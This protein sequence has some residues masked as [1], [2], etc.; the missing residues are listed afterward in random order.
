MTPQS[1]TTESL[2]LM[3]VADF[4][5]SIRDDLSNLHDQGT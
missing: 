4:W 5:R 3:T 2:G 1:D